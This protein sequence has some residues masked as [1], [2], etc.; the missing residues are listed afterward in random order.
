MSCVNTHIDKFC[1]EF[2]SLNLN[3]GGFTGPTLEVQVLGDRGKFYEDHEDFELTQSLL[4]RLRGAGVPIPG[5]WV[6]V[7]LKTSRSSSGVIT[8]IRLADKVWTEVQNKTIG[9]NH[10]THGDIMLGSEYFNVSGVA[11]GSHTSPPRNL[12]M[13]YNALR[14]YYS[15]LNSGKSYITSSGAI[16]PRPYGM[17]VKDLF[18]NFV[19]GLPDP[20]VEF[21]DIYYHAKQ[22]FDA[23]NLDG[24]GINGLLNSTGTQYDV[25]SSIAAQHGYV[26][27]AN[28]VTGHELIDINSINNFGKKDLIYSDG[29]QIPDEAVSSSIERDYGSGYSQS[30]R[31]FFETPGRYRRD[32]TSDENSNDGTDDIIVRTLGGYQHD[33]DSMD[34]LIDAGVIVGET[35]DLDDLA[36]NVIKDHPAVDELGRAWQITAQGE[37]DI[38]F[39]GIYGKDL[40]A[41]GYKWYTNA[42]LNIDESSFQYDAANAMGLEKAWSK[43]DG[44]GAEQLMSLYFENYNRFQYKDDWNLNEITHHGDFDPSWRGGDPVDDTFGFENFGTA[45]MPRGNK[46]WYTDSGGD[47]SFVGFTTRLKNSPFSAAVYNEDLLNKGGDVG[48]LHSETKP[49]FS[50]GSS[51]LGA[52]PKQGMI[53]LDFGQNSMPTLNPD[54]YWERYETWI[55]ST[56]SINSGELVFN[57]VAAVNID[58]L[59]TEVELMFNEVRDALENVLKQNPSEVA[60]IG[61]YGVESDIVYNFG[62]PNTKADSVNGRP[63]NTLTRHSNIPENEQDQYLNPVSVVYRNRG[64]TPAC[65]SAN[66]LFNRKFFSF[67]L[68]VSLFETKKYNPATGESEDID[69]S[70]RYLDDSG[71]ITRSSFQEIKNSGGCNIS[72]PYLDKVSFS[73]INSFYQI[74]PQAEKHLEG[75]SISVALGKLTTNYSFSQKVVI[76]DYRGLAASKVQLQNLIG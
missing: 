2:L 67:N 49:G 23:I 70:I 66:T 9:L 51:T 28:G 15:R 52:E 27:S 75:L 68:A 59:R 7:S 8:T 14:S 16:A 58:R 18:K 36:W 60:T 24:K 20:R 19:P 74:P 38:D 54:C 32:F 34:G 6:V 22:L 57:G 13:S 39:D 30:S 71:I 61:Y 69:R 12:I 25:V 33:S 46:T 26:Y 41:N 42:N 21:G 37:S 11:V 17:S 50:Y 29:V 48:A 62:P 10:K 56:S 3:M 73:L 45:N 1:N 72:V 44:Y 76:P 53:I 35:F 4:G 31:M 43:G 40:K 55:D 63:P 5:E 47:I 64:S 65:G